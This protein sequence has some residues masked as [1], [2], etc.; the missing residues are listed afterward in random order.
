MPEGMTPYIV[1][2]VTRWKPAS[3]VPSKPRVLKMR[4][5]LG[6]TLSEFRKEKQ[7][8]MRDIDTISL[9]YLSEIERG[10]KEASSEI[11]EALCDSIGVRLSDVLRSTADKLEEVGK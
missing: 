5:Y 7:I 9:S 3:V 10:K 11:L 6:E 4:G 8:T 1:N 2:G